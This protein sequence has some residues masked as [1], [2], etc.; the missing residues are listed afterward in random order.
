MK[1]YQTIIGLSLVAISIVVSSLILQSQETES[2]CDEL[3][4]LNKNESSKVDVATE[5]KSYTLET[6]D[7]E[8]SSV[9]MTDREKNEFYKNKQ[10]KDCLTLKVYNGNENIVIQ[11]IDLKID[12]T[13]RPRSK[14]RTNDKPRT[15][16]ATVNCAPLSCKTVYVQCL[17]VPSYVVHSQ[18][19]VRVISMTGKDI[20]RAAE[21]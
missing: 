10:E 20:K 5:F 9:K 4:E 17:A 21:K 6:F 16:R 18:Y 13:T 3:R 14:G 15:Y 11:T 1:N 8:I 7:A 2:R 19:N 12:M